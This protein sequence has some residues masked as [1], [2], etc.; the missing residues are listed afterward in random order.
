MRT[1]GGG[2]LIRSDAIPN[3]GS[4]RRVLGR[5]RSGC[6]IS[7]PCLAASSRMRKGSQCVSCTENASS[8][9]RTDTMA[10]TVR[11]RG[12]FDFLDTPT[13]RHVFSTGGARRVR[14][15]A[16]K[17]RSVQKTIDSSGMPREGRS[18][19]ALRGNRLS[20]HKPAPC[21]PLIWVRA[22]PCR[23]A[24]ISVRQ[25]NSGGC[26][27]SADPGTVRRPASR[28]TRVS[29]T[30]VDIETIWN[31]DGYEMRVLPRLCEQSS[32]PRGSD[33]FQFCSEVE[34]SGCG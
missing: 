31:L 17:P 13:S 1:D 19:R 6:G 24:D 2:L 29:R 23:F 4:P 25:P 18:Q 20:G 9:L 14:I 22:Q 16:G 27:R 26:G 28:R 21:T 33:R 30:V 34:C 32:T 10:L 8:P 7:R 15:G 12:R 11:E 3:R 5:P